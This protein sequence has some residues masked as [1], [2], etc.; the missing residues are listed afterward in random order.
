MLSP[1]SAVTF[2]LSLGLVC[3]HM[4]HNPAQYLLNSWRFEFVT[5]EKYRPLI[6]R[7]GRISTDLIRAD[8]YNP[9]YPWP[10]P[11]RSRTP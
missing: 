3:A 2:L 7:I 11:L 8:P 9:R 10:I 4:E 6:E 5:T 1:W